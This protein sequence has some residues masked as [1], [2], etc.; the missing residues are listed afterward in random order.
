MLYTEIHGSQFMALNLALLSVILF[1]HLG[2]LRHP[3]GLCHPSRATLFPSVFLV[4]FPSPYPSRSTWEEMT[5]LCL[6]PKPC[7][8]DVDA[9]RN[10]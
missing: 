3:Q 1:G 2:S 7:P 10:N 8:R 6:V 4:G 9:Q 5:V